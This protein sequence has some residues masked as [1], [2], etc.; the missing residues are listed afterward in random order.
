MEFRLDLYFQHH[1]GQTLHPNLD[2]V[3]KMILGDIKISS[4][5]IPKVSHCI[6]TVLLGCILFIYENMIFF[7]I[8][9]KI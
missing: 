7:I 8:G 9:D 2:T 5:P 4:V 6:V 3:V 1:F